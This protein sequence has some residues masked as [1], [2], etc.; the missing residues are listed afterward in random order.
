M[1]YSNTS[2]HSLSYV[3][4]QALASILRKSI[5]YLKVWH[6]PKSTRASWPEGIWRWSCA[7]D[8]FPKRFCAQFC[9]RLD[10]A[11]Q[12]LNCFAQCRI[13]FVWECFWYATLAF[14]CQWTFCW[15]STCGKC[16][17]KGEGR[18]RE[19]GKERINVFRTPE[20]SAIAAASASAPKFCANV[21]QENALRQN[22]RQKLSY[23]TLCENRP[24][25]SPWLHSS[26]I[27]LN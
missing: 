6:C 19:N 2:L 21:D 7:G 1:K 10:C 14:E 17:G 16:D 27:G 4:M 22:L 5:R 9:P 13:H 11:W 3:H 25:D 20:S 26:R 12:V 8:S 23:L 15:I 24:S 18:K